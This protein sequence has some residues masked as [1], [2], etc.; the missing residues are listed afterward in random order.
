MKLPVVSYSSFVMLTPAVTAMALSVQQQTFF[1]LTNLPYL[2]THL[3][4]HHDVINEKDS[5]WMGSARGI[6]LALL[7]HPYISMFLIIVLFHWIK[8]VLLLLSQCPIM[9][10]SQISALI[11]KRKS[12]GGGDGGSKKA[13]Y[14]D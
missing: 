10:L 1:P 7:C 2:C 6:N 13:R 5:D 9:S 8:Y 3:Q 14:D 12:G 11:D 4:S